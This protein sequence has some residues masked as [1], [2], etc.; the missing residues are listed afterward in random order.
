[1]L[2]N[3]LGHLRYAL[4][5]GLQGSVFRVSV[6]PAFQCSRNTDPENEGAIIIR[7]VAYYDHDDTV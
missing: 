4:F 3:I 6:V 2:M 5:V 1:M 7:N